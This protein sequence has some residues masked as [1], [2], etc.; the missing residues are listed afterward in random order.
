MWPHVILL[1]PYNAGL[2]LARRMVRLGAEVTVVESHRIV[3][4]S[5]GVRSIV[6]PYK[7][8]GQEW[9]E[10]LIRLARTS[11]ECVVL[12]GTDRASEWLVQASERLPHNVRTF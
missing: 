10:L 8:D 5:R 4:H 9:L 11:A 7:R 2:A 6:D 3:G 1:D 12:T